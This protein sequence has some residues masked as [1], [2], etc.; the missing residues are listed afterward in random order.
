MATFNSDDEQFFRA[1]EQAAYRLPVRNASEARSADRS[2]RQIT[3]RKTRT[4]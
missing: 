2:R 3:D 1:H 4:Q